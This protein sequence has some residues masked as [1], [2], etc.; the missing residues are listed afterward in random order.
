MASWHNDVSGTDWAIVGAPGEDGFTGAAYIYSYAPG[1]SDWKMEARLVAPDATFGSEFGFSVAI[2]H[3]TVA[4]G[5]PLHIADFFFGAA[6]VFV[7]DEATGDWTQQGDEFNRGDL[8]F[9]LAVA[10][11]GDDL[12]ISQPGGDKV[13]TYERTGTTW[14][15]LDTL[16]STSTKPGA[17]FGFS[18]RDRRA[19]FARWFTAR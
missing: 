12:A 9:G 11:A 18:P 10:I 2:D 4:V 3:E 19:A 1:S 14:S 8:D 6:Y 17:A 7:R 16:T 5:A 15:P 13:F